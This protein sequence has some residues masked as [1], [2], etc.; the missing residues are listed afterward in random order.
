MSLMPTGKKINHKK[1]YAAKAKARKREE[2]E[3]RQAEYAS[4]SLEYKL[5]NAGP[6]ERAKLESRSK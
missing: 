5:K 3:K 4:K 6:K 1:G 2:A